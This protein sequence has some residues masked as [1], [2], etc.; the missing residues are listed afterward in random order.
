MKEWPETR[1]LL[2]KHGLGEVTLAHIASGE[3]DWDLIYDASGAQ[4]VLLDVE[5]GNTLVGASLS[6]KEA[7]ELLS[8][9]EFEQRDGL[10]ANRP[11]AFGAG[12]YDDWT[13]VRPGS[14]WPGMIRDYRAGIDAMALSLPAGAGAPLLFLCRHTLELQLKAVIMVGQD[15]LGLR[16]DLPGHH[17]LDRLWTAAQPMI[18]ACGFQEDLGSVRAL[19]DQYHLADPHSFNFRY[20]VN[21]KNKPVQHETFMHAFSKTQHLAKTKAAFDLLDRAIRRAQMTGLF[22][23]VAAAKLE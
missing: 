19:V 22:R 17:E 14:D 23:R 21:T 3:V 2:T 12:D 11:D 18:V 10:L 15:A 6:A 7:D 16:L 13:G 8:K 9:W 5:T 4:L 20:P 1:R